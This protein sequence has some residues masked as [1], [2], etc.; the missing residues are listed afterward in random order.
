MQVLKLDYLHCIMRE[1]Y[2][3]SCSSAWDTGSGPYIDHAVVEEQPKNS[4][5]RSGRLLEFGYHHRLNHSLQ[6]TTSRVL[7]EIHA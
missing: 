5:G 2:T 6:V 3:W 7:I 4:G 1:I